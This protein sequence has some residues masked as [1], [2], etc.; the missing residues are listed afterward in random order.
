MQVEICKMTHRAQ[1]GHTGGSLS[2]IDILC[3]LYGHR[4]RVNQMTQIG[5]IETDSFFQRGMHHKVCM[6]SLLRW[7]SSPMKTSNLTALKEEFVKDTLT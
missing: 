3:G 7:V 6:Q 2:E 5:K 4:L 1:A